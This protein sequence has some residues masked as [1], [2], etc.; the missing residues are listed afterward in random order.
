VEETF[1][2]PRRREA[3]GRWR[4]DDGGD[5]WQDRGSLVNGIGP[6]CSY[7]GSLNPEKFMELV[8]Q[9]WW[10]DPTDK[11]YKAYLARPLDEAQIAE[12]REQWM[13]RASMSPA[14]MAACAEHA[15]D[16]QAAIEHEWEQMAAARGHGD[17]VAKFYYQHLSSAQM[18]RFIEL[19]NSKQMK[20]G[21]PG[22]FYVLP[23]FASP[24]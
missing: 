22:H 5:Q 20:I 21:M 1:T 23:Y 3:P 17:A 8:E 16:V 6:S 12:E 9:G 18:D 15:D 19:V 24:T 7:C 11:S 4:G 2:C 13:T 14:R 10:V